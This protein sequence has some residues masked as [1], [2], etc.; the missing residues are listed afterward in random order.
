MKA[1]EQFKVCVCALF[2]Y[3]SIK[4]NRNK[5]KRAEEWWT[6]EWPTMA[7][8]THQLLNYSQR[9][10]LT[11]LFWLDYSVKSLGE[12][13]TIHSHQVLK[14]SIHQVN[15]IQVS[16]PSMSIVGLPAGLVELPPNYRKFNARTGKASR[17]KRRKNQFDLLFAESMYSKSNLD[18][19]I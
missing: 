15:D 4:W 17:F 8:A 7:S 18:H 12:L 10:S 13:L 6:Q 16:L 19:P 9:E 2:D 3:L 1:R 5:N 11:E 14:L